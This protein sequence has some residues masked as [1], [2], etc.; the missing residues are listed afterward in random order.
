M[1]KPPKWT[2]KRILCE[3]HERGMTLQ[4]LALR[5]DRN[6]SSMRNVWTRPNSIDERIIAEFIDEKPE[7]LWPNRYPK[8][9]TRIYDSAKYGPLESQKSNASADKRV[10]A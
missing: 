7:T 4:Q 2:P 8:T 5:N 6:P 10:A 9:T 3:I 1:S